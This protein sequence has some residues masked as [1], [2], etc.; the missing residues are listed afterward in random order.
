MRV[1]SNTSSSRMAWLRLS[2]L[3]FV[4]VFHPDIM[5]K[6]KV[7]G[8]PK[9]GFRLLYWNIQNGMWS[10]QG[11][12]YSAFVKWVKA[13][14]PDVCVW[15]EAQ[16]I[17]Y[18]G[19]DKGMKPEERYLTE[20]WGE[21]AARYGHKYWYV[22][23]HR[24]NYPQVITSKY[25]IENVERIVGNADTIVSHGA[26]WATITIKNRKINVVTLHTWPQSYAM[27][28]KDRNA[29][30]RQNGGSKFR[31]MEV[32][33]IYNHTLGSVPGGEN[34]L[35]MM[36][37]DFNSRSPLDNDVY[38][39]SMDDP[40]YWVN[41]Y[42]LGQ[43]PYVDVIACKHPGKFFTSTGGQSRIDFVYC[44]PSLCDM[45]SR[46]EII[47]DEYTKP[48]RDPKKLSNFWHPSDH[49]PIVVDFSMK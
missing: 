25:P 32:E 40:R 23:G 12:N 41:H 44:T 29:S 17:Y 11:D 26:G 8:K 22:G 47:E 10:G 49:L 31:R 35:W 13:Q 5:A 3:A 16:T 30:T 45:V 21:L 20:H 33:Y 14:K 28:A 36:M 6:T 48:V 46:A 9:N 15:C 4:L 24:D 38:D 19:T 7:P 42:I 18:T 27:G 1:F 34:G 43:T 37:G 39:Y 2:L